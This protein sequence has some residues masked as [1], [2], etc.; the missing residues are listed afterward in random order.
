MA[1]EYRI[2]LA[3]EVTDLGAIEDAIRGVDPS[4]LVDIDPVGGALRIAATIAEGELVALV[5]LAGLLISRR[6]VLLLPS[7]CC[8]GCSG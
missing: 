1:M 3:Q 7:I 5:R 6:Q 8:G 4:A 2:E